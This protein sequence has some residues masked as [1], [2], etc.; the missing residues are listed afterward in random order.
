MEIERLGPYQIIGIL[1]RGGM[2][3]VYKAV[4]HDTGEAAAVKL[5][6]ADLAEEEGFR[7]RFEAEI[8][9]LRKLHHPNIVRLFGFGE[10][11]GLLFYAMELV[12][13]N[14][15]EEELRRGRRFDWREVTR[16]GIETCRAL[17]HA[18]DRGVI[19][20]D[21]KP[22]NL[23]LAADGCVKL[24]DFG[25][26]RLFGYSRLT[27]AGNV[28]GTAEYMAPEQAAGQPIDSRADLYSLGA[29]M[30]ALLARRPVFRGKSLPEMLHK[31]QHE[32]PEPIR[33]H[34]SD[35]PEELER[36]LSQLL[37][38]SPD[39]RIPNA[40]V[41]ARRLEAMLQSLSVGHET[42]AADSSWFHSAE[43][44]LAQ[45]GSAEAA[46]LV[47]AVPA[48]L[49]LS[50]AI[51]E[52]PREKEIQQPFPDSVCLP[53]ESGEGSAHSTVSPVVGDTSPGSR[54]VAVSEHELGQTDEEEDRP[55]MFSWQTGA[56]VIAL[57]LVGLG[58]W[59]LLQ[60][61]TA[62]VLAARIE[63]TVG[64]GSIGELRLAENDIRDFLSRYSGD[65]RAKT[66]RGYE[67]QLELDDLQRSFDS[68]I[69]RLTG[70]KVLS[71]IE[72]AFSEAMN[73]V[74]LDPEVGIAKLQAI[75]DLY[76][77]GDRTPGPNEM[78]LILAQ[79]RLAQLREEVKKRSAEQL[80]LLEER[81][82][83]ADAL[84]KNEPEQAEKMYRA[85]VELYSDKPWA[86]DPVRRARHALRTP[87]KGTRSPEA[88]SP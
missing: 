53:K 47:S 26:A 43:S 59:W 56:L 21:I 7:N 65:R 54:F 33:K 49:D 66:Y 16:I 64:D 41:L 36:I 74:R 62:D 72:R 6:S 44:V 60:P 22:G 25:I 8:E 61:P 29:L 45:E 88:A 9:T 82:A 46:S 12:D 19:H 87:S 57:L 77:Q 2:G 51:R 79:R 75:V 50:G 5:L 63:A 13:G 58:A 39:R 42:L 10:Q 78:C 24:S 17:R 73:Y 4:R 11:E 67:K 86:A 81:L 23:L 71:P 18:H 83:A 1:G 55:P 20:R 69:K 37:E 48:T 70:K 52:E 34:V 76:E 14:S 28:L 27:S 84:R 3:A 35:L 85:V 31:Q 40:D 38:K 30:Y 15:L 32:Q 80:S 68:P